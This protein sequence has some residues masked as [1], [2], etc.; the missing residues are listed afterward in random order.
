MIPRHAARLLLA[1]GLALGVSVPR[2]AHAQDPE[3]VEMARQR[4]R[5]GV[6]FYDQREYDKARLSF[7]QAYA[8]KPHPAVLLNL[9]QSELRSGHPDDA[10][11]HFSEYLHN[12]TV[13]D[14][15]KQETELG[16]AAAK[17][18][19][20]EVTV[21][22]DTP[23]A[24]LTVDGADRGTAPLTSPL[25]LMPGTHS[26]DATMTDRHATKSVTTSAGQTT[27]VNLN[28]RPPSTAPVPAEHTELQE[29]PEAAPA[30]EKPAPPPEE[31]AASEEAAPEPTP[32]NHRP[33][34]FK[35]LGQHPVAIGGVAVG[36]LGIGGS[37]TFGLLSNRSYSVANQDKTNLKNYWYGTP[38]MAGDVNAFANDANYNPQSNGP[39][40]L[41]S[42]GARIL[43]GPRVSAYQETCKDFQ[44]H[45]NSGDTEKTL[46]IVSGIV[47]GAA[48]IG[49]VVYYFV[50]SGS[51]KTA[52]VPGKTFEARLMP[53]A[54]PGSSG[55]D[56]VGQF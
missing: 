17:S 28:L 32:E 47:G 8:L 3:T 6:Q 41:P 36:A 40:S 35:W 55:L 12:N 7:R 45:A 56:V 48:I 49:T 1:A 10:A 30:E 37:V 51:E 33:P 42:D 15:D 18:K 23:G 9:A 21:V 19:V 52:A 39:C 11:T 34:F 54:A 2:G 29:T 20:A 4:F 16:F 14:T 26:F 13:S 22:V 24:Q 44:D 27:S 50:D 5:E 46:A 31:Q 53:W 38:A 43:P 25:Y